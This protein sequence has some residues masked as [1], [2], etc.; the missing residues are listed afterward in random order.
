MFM[1]WFRFTLVEFP[2]E[3][4]EFL[5]FGNRLLDFLEAKQQKKVDDLTTTV[6]DL[7][8]ALL[9]STNRLEKAI[10]ESKQ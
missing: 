6:Q 3:M 5:K 9:I 4:G 2:P 8:Q 7:T 1:K 10:K